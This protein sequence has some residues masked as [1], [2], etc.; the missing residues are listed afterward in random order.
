VSPFITT[1]CRKNP[2]EPLATAEK[3]EVL[4]PLDIAESKE[5]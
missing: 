4:D 1:R 2:S 5:Y 3:A